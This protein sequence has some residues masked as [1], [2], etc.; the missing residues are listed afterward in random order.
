MKAAEVSHKIGDGKTM[1]GIRR[2]LGTQM[3]IEGI[4]VT[5]IAQV[6]GHQDTDVTRAYI[7]LNIEGL[8]ECALTFD[9]LI[10]NAI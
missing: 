4:P 8:R 6:L 9:S 1:H 7:S 5:T 10:G 3:T 2:M